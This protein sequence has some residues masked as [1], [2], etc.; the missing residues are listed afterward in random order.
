METLVSL[1][2]PDV[3]ER[4]W[5]HLALDQGRSRV[6]LHVQCEISLGLK[7]LATALEFTWEFH[8][9]VV[10][11]LDADVVA[12]RLFGSMFLAAVV[13]DEML[14]LELGFMRGLVVS[15]TNF[16]FHGLFTDGALEQAF[17]LVLP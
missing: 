17:V 5:T 10:L 13:A 14:L 9:N 15:L 7:F 4:L 2:T 3:F 11:V 6:R 16:R 1:V 8:G 12:Q